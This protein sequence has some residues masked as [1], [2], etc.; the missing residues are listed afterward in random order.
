MPCSGLGVFAPLILFAPPIEFAEL[1]TL[2]PDTPPGADPLAGFSLSAPFAVEVE[3]DPLEVC[4]SLV[5]G[6]SALGALLF[7][8]NKKDIVVA[9]NGCGA[10]GLYFECMRS[11]R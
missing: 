2:L 9:R 8:P 4:V 5:A 6:G 3:P 11:F 10:N 7:F 1:L